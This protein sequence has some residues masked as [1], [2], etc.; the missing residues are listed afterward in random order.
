MKDLEFSPV[1]K[2]Q[3]I[4]IKDHIETYKDKETYFTEPLTLVCS[5]S[6]NLYW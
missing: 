3:N 4:M 6:W 5:S 2:E 1:L